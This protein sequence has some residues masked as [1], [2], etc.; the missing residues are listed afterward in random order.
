[1]PDGNRRRRR[2]GLLADPL[3]GFVHGRCGMRD[4]PRPADPSRGIQQAERVRFAAPI[5]PTNHSNVSACDLL[6]DSAVP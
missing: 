1:M 5:N 4:R 6:S 3:H 2:A